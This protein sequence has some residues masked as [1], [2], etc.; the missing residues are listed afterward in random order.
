VDTAIPAPCPKCG[1]LRKAADTAPAWQ[2]PSCGIAYSK[3]SD[4]PAKAAAA[5]D[6]R[7]RTLLSVGLRDRA[8]DV[9][10]WVYIALALAFLG[11][12]VV[13]PQLEADRWIPL[14]LA[15]SA[16][17]FW[18]RAYRRL[19]TIEDVPTSTIAAA[20]QGYVELNGTAVAAAGDTLVGHLTR[21]PC[22]WYRYSWYKSGQEKGGD[23]GELGVPF[24]LRDAT[25]DCLVD[26]TEAEVV[27]D[28]CQTWAREA[29]VFQEWSIRV[30]DPVYVIG[31]F[32][33]GGAAAERH[34]NMKA[35][36]ALAAQQRD[37]QAYAS[38]Y[39]LDRDGKVDRR[40]AAVAREAQ[41]REILERYVR[42]GG[43]H[44]LGPSRDGRPFLVIGAGSR[45]IASRYRRLALA[46]LGVFF[47]SLALVAWLW[48]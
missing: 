46:H 30:G 15:V 13:F 35:S 7:A 32:S 40:E 41:R 6:L 20:A 16:F 48:L 12:I 25:G 29:I 18:L 26:A 27:C 17:A 21:L 28:R 24:I 37:A 33:T 22:V 38:R 42:Q 34:V 19:R 5:P 9:A 45:S 44:T 36:Y 43:V 47:L 39:D 10:I 8:G 2:C 3:F 11:L 4:A 1:Y 14:V 23:M 31:H